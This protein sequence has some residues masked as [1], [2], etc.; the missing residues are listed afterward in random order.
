MEKSKKKKKTKRNPDVSNLKTTPHSV[1]KEWI[2]VENN[3]MKSKLTTPINLN[4]VTGIAPEVTISSPGHFSAAVIRFKDKYKKI[5]VNTFSS[6]K[7]VTTGAKNEDAA[8]FTIIYANYI[9]GKSHGS[10]F[11]TN[12][13][14]LSNIVSRVNIPGKFIDIH[15]L[16]KE[17]SGIC[18]YNP[19]KFPGAI[20]RFPEGH[21]PACNIFP[22]G[23][24]ILPGPNT[25]EYSHQCINH[26]YN[27]I[28]PYLYDKEIPSKKRKIESEQK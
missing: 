8:I 14:K 26:A 23:V 5:A 17:N 10:K 11:I 20:M 18:T 13:L 27:I 12:N 3:V 6:G 22:G 24:F 21:T 9:L 2:K 7:I 4:S 25:E 15:R 1:P 16:T 28:E 19:E